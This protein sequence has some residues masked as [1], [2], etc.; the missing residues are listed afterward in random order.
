MLAEDVALFFAGRGLEGARAAPV[1]V[2]LGV[3]AY[4][5]LFCWLQAAQPLRLWLGGL[6][7]HHRT[8]S[9]QRLTECVNALVLVTG[10]WPLM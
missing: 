8:D 5:S 4:A 3:A 2:P 1:L 9:H 6:D 10:Q 7:R